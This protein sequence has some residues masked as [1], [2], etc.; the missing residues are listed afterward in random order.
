MVIDR[1]G[2][3]LEVHREDAMVIARCGQV[4]AVRRED[5]MVT[6]RCGQVLEARREGVMV[7]VRCGRVLEV[8]REVAMVTVRCGRVLEVRREVAMVTVLCGRGLGVRPG[9]RDRDGLTVRARCVS[10]RV[11]SDRETPGPPGPRCRAEYPRPTRL[12]LRVTSRRCGRPGSR[13]GA[14]SRVRTNKTRQR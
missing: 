14:R 5:A 1:C 9:A 12:C 6:V 4:L 8:R 2:R 7:I 10:R 11:Q 13:T 3:V